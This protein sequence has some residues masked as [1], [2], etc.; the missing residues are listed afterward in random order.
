MSYA[1]AH[2]VTKKNDEQTSCQGS[3]VLRAKSGPEVKEVLLD[4]RLFLVVV[5]EVFES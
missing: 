4:L 1:F 5:K 2:R 3:I